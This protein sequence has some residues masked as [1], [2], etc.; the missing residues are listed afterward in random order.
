ML[1]SDHLTD[2]D[3]VLLADGELQSARQREAREHLDACWSCRARMAEIQGTISEFV[4]AY[5]DNL[6]AQLTPVAGPRALLRAQ[7]ERSMA[8]KTS[9]WWDRLFAG[10]GAALPAKTAAS[11]MVAC[12][13][14]FAIY[15]RG[16]SRRPGDLSIPKNS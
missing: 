10:H 2:R 11:L 14:V 5:H 16:V 4:H 7:L 1:Q 13:A 9:G 15:E 6:D 3:M 8:T 12:L